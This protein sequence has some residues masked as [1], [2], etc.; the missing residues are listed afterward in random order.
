M[1]VVAV[2]SALNVGIG[3][4]KIQ[5]FA[6]Q[7]RSKNGGLVNNIFFD[8]LLYL[9]MLPEDNK[10][11]SYTM[12]NPD[13]KCLMTAYSPFIGTEQLDLKDAKE[14]TMTF[15][16]TNFTPPIRTFNEQPVTKLAKNLHASVIPNTKK[17][18]QGE[19][20][21]THILVKENGDEIIALFEANKNFSFGGFI[22]YIKEFIKVYCTQ[23]DINSD[24]EV[25]YTIIPVGNFFELLNSV[26]RVKAASIYV[27]KKI[28]GDSELRLTN[29]LDTFKESLVL[30]VSAKRKKDIKDAMQEIAAKFRAKGTIVKKIRVEGFQPE[31][32]P[33]ILDTEICQKKDIVEVEIDSRTRAVT[34]PKVLFQ[35][36]GQL[37]KALIGEERV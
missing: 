31:G 33:I 2:T 4:K 26:D 22:R 34:D 16:R 24:F 3:P 23:N 36:M 21:K 13:R 19:E 17:A 5:Y 25:G 8:V 1:G 11:S 9:S 14:I 35:A 7:V 10:T 15:G 27:D 32:A 30:N 20:E 12:S 29:F 28:L 37:L 18:N 6:L